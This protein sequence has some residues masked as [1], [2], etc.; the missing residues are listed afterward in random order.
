MAVKGC[1]EVDSTKI[2]RR[3]SKRVTLL[4]FFGIAFFRFSF[5]SFFPSSFSSLFD[6]D[7]L[8]SSK[9]PIGTVAVDTSDIKPL[10]QKGVDV[11]R[12]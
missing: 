1:G 2:L 8:W 5:F 4:H 3:E 11:D 9:R 12:F 6:P 10:I 7:T